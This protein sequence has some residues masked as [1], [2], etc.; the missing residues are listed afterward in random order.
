MTQ[1]T[2]LRCPR[3]AGALTPSTRGG[4]GVDLCGA[5]G[6]VWLG[7]EA[8]AAAAEEPGEPGPVLR[9]VAYLKCPVCRTIMNRRN[10][11]RFSGVILDECPR[12]GTWADR[13]ELDRIHSFLQRGGLDT[14]ARKET[15]E[16]RL[17]AAVEGYGTART[18]RATI[19]GGFTVEDA[20]VS[21]L[22]T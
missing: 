3:C 4:V 5:C 7:T 11:E 17:A 12:H 13:G 1:P 10:F 21:L 15:E 18:A 8:L 19:S 22:D 16:R 9:D 2:G 14:R 20:L 6:G